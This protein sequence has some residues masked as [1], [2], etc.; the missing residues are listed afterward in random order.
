MSHLVQI[1]IQSFPECVCVCMGG[2]VK[3]ANF[4]LCLSIAQRQ[5]QGG[6]SSARVTRR[7]SVTHLDAKK[8]SK[9]NPKET[10]CI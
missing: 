3:K 2:G 5:Q 1:Q 6:D 9:F 8:S 4:G 7:V 10:E